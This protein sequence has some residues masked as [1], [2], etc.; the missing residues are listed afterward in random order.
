MSFSDGVIQQIKDS[1]D[2]AELIGE[3]LPL[4]KVGKNYRSKC[5]FHEDSSPSFYVTPELNIFHCFGCGKSGDIFTFIMEYE[6]VPFVEALKILAEK[7]GVDIKGFHGDNSVLYSI[8]EFAADFFNDNLMNSSK[9]LNYVKKRGLNID[10]IQKFKL[11]FA[12]RGNEFLKEARKEFKIEDLI[13]SG[14]VKKYRGNVRD[15]FFLRLMFPIFSTGGKIIGFGGRRLSKKGPKYLNS[16]DTPIHK[17]GKNLY[18]IWHS[19]EEIRKESSVILV[20]GYFD[21]LSI[22]QQGIKNCV[23]CLGTAL[24]EDQAELLSRYADEVTIFFDTD[25][26]GKAATLRSL[27]MMLNHGVEVKIGISDKMKDP[28]EII[29]N[30]GVEEFKKLLEC[31]RNLVDFTMENI[32]KECDLSS[33][34]GLTRAVDRVMSILSQIK[35][36]V[37]KQI[38]REKIADDLMLK[39]E[40]LMDRT[41][42][43]N[44]VIGFLSSSISP[45]EKCEL[46]LLYALMKSP[47]CKDK[48]FSMLNENEMKI[49]ALRKALRLLKEE[50]EIDRGEVIDGLSKQQLNYFVSVSQKPEISVEFFTIKLKKYLLDRS[51]KEKLR[52]LEEKSEDEDKVLIQIRDLRKEKEDILRRGIN[53]TGYS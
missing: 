10:T 48:V 30:Q 43:K 49:P 14:L 18:S 52:S 41:S 5:P 47:E 16:P 40:I 23:A 45:R 6:K 46:S 19:K 31:S 34:S 50:Q 27:G 22:F 12:E 26:A 44:N 32:R 53:G 1:L 2:I 15:R 11:G 7:A 17:K 39:E 21:Y 25:S 28:D 9:V 20:E 42:T 38:Y 24:T 13:K 37:K 4:K 29:S 8:H 3:Y 35:D 36:P 51:I 33:P